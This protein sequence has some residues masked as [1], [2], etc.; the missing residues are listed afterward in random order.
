MT[1]PVLFHTAIKCLAAVAQFRGLAVAPEG[2][3]ARYG[4]TGQEPTSALLL[5][6]SADIGMR[7]KLELR[8]WAS[9]WAPTVFP[10]L[11][12]LADGNWVV[13]VG[14]QLGDTPRVAVIDPMQPT[15]AV[16]LLEERQF[17]RRWTGEIILIQQEA[18]PMAAAA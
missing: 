2:L 13:L 14:T 1:S 10:A 12:R 7:A 3:V 17:C 8:S 16:L 9:L 15:T 18:A 6:I 5:R 11:A 4:L